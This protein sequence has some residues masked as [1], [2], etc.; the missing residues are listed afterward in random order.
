MRIAMTAVLLAA[1]IPAQAQNVEKQLKHVVYAANFAVASIWYNSENPINMQV[2]GTAFFVTPDG[3]FVTAA[4]VLQQYKPKSAQMTIGLRERSGSGSGLW[5]DV[6]EKDEAHDLALCKVPYPLKFREDPKNPGTE[7]PTASLR[8]ANASPETGDFIAIAG[9]P[10]GSWTPAIQLGTVAAMRTTNPNGGRVPAGQRDLLEISAAGNQGNSGSPVIDLH[11]GEVV[12]VIVQAQVAPLFTNLQ[13]S[14]PLAQS[15]GL[16]FA[17]P[18]NWVQDLLKRHNVK[19]I[20]QLPP[21][22]HTS[23]YPLPET[24]PK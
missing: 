15:S 22:G 14:V 11:T 7:E 24:P 17:V 6:V 10:L 21:K 5:F 23:Y 1:I 20:A 19:N 13:G 9:F 18:A 16:M 8:I 12:G 2:V 4:H 3:Y